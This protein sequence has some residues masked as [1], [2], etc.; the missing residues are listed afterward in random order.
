MHGTWN[1]TLWELEHALAKRNSRSYDG[2]WL[3]F[4]RSA[5]SYKYELG[6]QWSCLVNSQSSVREHII[7]VLSYSATLPLPLHYSHFHVPLG[8][9]VSRGK[10]GQ[11]K[12]SKRCEK[13]LFLARTIFQVTNNEAGEVRACEKVIFS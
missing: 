2:F 4:L 6:F 7:T 10:P 13:E 5:S 11:A 3:G 12:L 8:S 9:L 1:L